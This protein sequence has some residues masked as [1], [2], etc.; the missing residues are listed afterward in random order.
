MDQEKKKLN[1]VHEKDLSNL[2]VQLNLLDKVNAGEI[3]CKFCS[4]VITLQNI[5]SIL[6]ESGGFN[7]VC[8]APEC[9]NKLMQY[10]DEKRLQKE[11]L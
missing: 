11:Q 1:A 4:T 3:K 6:P 2:L 9:V 10:L 5:H 7:F 8:D